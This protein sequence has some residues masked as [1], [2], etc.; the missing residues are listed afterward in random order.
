MS[1]LSEY[2]IISM[3]QSVTE[4][5]KIVVFIKSCY[6]IDCLYRASARL[7]GI[8]AGNY[9][10][11]NKDSNNLIVVAIRASINN[12]FDVLQT[13]FERQGTMFDFSNEEVS[14]KYQMIQINMDQINSMLG[15]DRL[16]KM[17]MNTEADTVLAEHLHQ[18]E[19][20]EHEAE[21][22]EQLLQSEKDL[23]RALKESQ[24]LYAES[25]RLR[26]RANRIR[27]DADQIE[28]HREALVTE[29]EE[30]RLAIQQ[31][32]DLLTNIAL[33]HGLQYT[34]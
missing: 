1:S 27:R 6:D 31:S 32:I 16:V 9:E 7:V 5:N 23:E 29:D 8:V 17:E 14:R 25:E 26:A 18:I 13:N 33:D 15:L 3:N 28:E 34:G 19:V 4:L 24:D 22:Q 21:I 12:A 10:V 20:R 2:D 30:L 11:W